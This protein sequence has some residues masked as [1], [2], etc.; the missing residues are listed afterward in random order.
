MNILTTYVGIFMDALDYVSL[1]DFLTTQDKSLSYKNRSIPD[2]YAP[3]AFSCLLSR[4]FFLAA[5]LL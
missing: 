5:V 2:A 1:C 3:K 4:D